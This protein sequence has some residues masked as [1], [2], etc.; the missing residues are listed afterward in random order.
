MKKSQGKFV[1]QNSKGEVLRVF[2]NLPA[3]TYF[4]KNLQTGRL[5]FASQ[6]SK[7]SGEGYVSLGDIEKSSATKGVVQLTSDL[8][9]TYLPDIR[10]TDRNVIVPED[11]QEEQFN[12]ILTYSGLAHISIII[13]VMIAGFLIEPL[14]TPEETVVKVVKQSKSFVRPQ[15]DKKT[16][17]VS[18]TKINRKVKPTKKV[19]SRK[20]KARK[21]SKKTRKTNSKVKRGQ[22]RTKVN[23]AQTGALGVLGGLKNGSRKSSGLNLNSLSNSRGSG[24]SGKGGKG[25][26]RRALPGKGLVATGVG[27]G[28]K[29]KGAGGYGTRGKG[30]GRAGYGKM[31]LAGAS[32]AFFQPLQNE[33]LIQGGLDKDQIDAVIRKNMGQIVY[34]YEKGL[35]VDPS[36]AG[37]VNVRFV[38]GGSG[39]V[40]AAKVASSS[41]GSATVDR[42]IINKLTKWKF[43]K[44]HGRVNVKVSYPFQLR[45]VGQG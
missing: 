45:R 9:L 19:T 17:R 2:K 7:V 12:K 44:P 41:V 36:A 4:G 15:F 25:G 16:V 1:V 10:K 6:K 14:F 28:G 37:R 33:A 40:A 29:A 34:C 3:K 27:S 31:S 21:Y 23:V 18:K 5:E 32:G 30:G 43:P 22:A 24:L 39:R 26:N 38:I 13:L 11:Q 42:C 35:Q 8:S 20:V